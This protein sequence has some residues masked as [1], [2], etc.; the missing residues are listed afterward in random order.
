MMQ[1]GRP[2][3]LRGHRIHGMADGDRSRACRMTGMSGWNYRVVQSFDR[4]EYFIA[5]VYY[6]GDEL[7]WVDDSRDCL[8][9]SGYDDLRGAVE[10]IRQAF[11]RP[12]LRVSADD[13]LVEATTISRD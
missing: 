7:S 4:S 2:D 9:W 11:D 12:L 3:S 1:G 10:M 13:R 5:E 8:R 6:N